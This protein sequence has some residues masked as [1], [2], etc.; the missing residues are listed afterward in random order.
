MLWLYTFIDNST[1]AKVESTSDTHSPTSPS[2]G[3]ATL[4]VHEYDDNEPPTPGAMLATVNT[5]DIYRGWYPPLQRTLWILSK[6]YR[7]VNVNNFRSWN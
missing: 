6:L 5:G 3:P 4:S 2:T 7:S 1:E